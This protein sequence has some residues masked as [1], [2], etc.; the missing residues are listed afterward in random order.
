MMGKGGHPEVS[1]GTGHALF[2]KLGR[3]VGGRCRHSVIVQT[4]HIAY[5]HS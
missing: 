4:V 5:I 1:R 3:G 2:L